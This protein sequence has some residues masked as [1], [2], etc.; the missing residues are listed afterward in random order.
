MDDVGSSGMTQTRFEALSREAV[1]S[2]LGELIALDRV[3]EAD[4]WGAE[5][6]RAELPGK[7]RYSQVALGPGGEPIGFVIA[8]RKGNRVHIHRLAVGEAHQGAGIGQRLVAAAAASALNDGLAMMTLK[9]SWAN[10]SA[11]RFY[12][13]LGFSVL[14]TTAQSSQLIAAIG[15]LVER[16]G[17]LG[18]TLN[19]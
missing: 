13:R 6:F 4:R 12:E 1:A 5:E 11:R 9:V 17:P 8:S 10:E 2:L 14:E 18:Q 3:I 7:F 19:K 16:L 15:D